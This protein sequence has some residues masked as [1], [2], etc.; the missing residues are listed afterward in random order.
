MTPR[1]IYKPE[2]HYDDVIEWI[3]AGKTLREFCRQDGRP[4]AAIVY[5]WMQADNSFAE[6]VARA[7]DIGY[8]VIAEEC[9]AVA[10]DDTRDWLDSSCV[11]RAKLRVETRQKL[12]ACWNPNRYGNKVAVG[13]D[14]TGAPIR[15]L[16][17]VE[18]AHRLQVLL[19]TVATRVAAPQLTD[20]EQELLS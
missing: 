10:D 20:E 5:G 12:L 2:D 9:L 15:V 6:R 8:D 14:A 16:T 11:Q 13:G 17:S 4:S 1:V 18:R 19:A 7:R 3:A